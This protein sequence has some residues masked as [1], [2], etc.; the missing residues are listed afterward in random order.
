MLSRIDIAIETINLRK[1][2]SAFLFYSYKRTYE[3]TTH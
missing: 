1:E 2:V 3:P